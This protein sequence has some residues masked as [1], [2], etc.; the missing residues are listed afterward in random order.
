[1]MPDMSSTVLEFA[2]SLTFKTSVQTVVNY[3]PVITYT[4]TTKQGVIYPSKSDDLKSLLIDNTLAYYTVITID[5]LD[6]NDLLSYK[7]KDFKL[8]SK[9]DFSDYGYYQF[10]FEE[11]KNA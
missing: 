6:I 5:N 8:F 7:S 1:M 11:I 9:Q 3:E 10:I 4:T 2:Q